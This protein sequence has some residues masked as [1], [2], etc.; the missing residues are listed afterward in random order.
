[1]ADLTALIRL[2]KYKVEEKQK[3]L[4][5]LFRE[6]ERFEAVIKGLQTQKDQERALAEEK[7]D[8]ETLTAYTLFAERVK[9]QIEFLQLG[10]SKVNSRIVVAQ[11][12]M[13]E[14]FGE[15]KKIEIIQENREA[16]EAKAELQRDSK[17]MDEIGLQGFMRAKEDK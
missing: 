2:R 12:A 1:M 15:L 6:A 10:L 3:A 14:A 17:T 8:Y 11:D 4:A 7:N 13:R 5:D 16:E 9:G